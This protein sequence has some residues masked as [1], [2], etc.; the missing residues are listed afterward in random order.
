MTENETRDP[1]KEAQEIE[2]FRR[3]IRDWFAKRSHCELPV[4]LKDLIEVRQAVLQEVC[5][6]LS[7][8]VSEYAARI[9]LTSFADRQFFSRWLNDVSRTFGVSLVCP[10]TG[11]T[12]TLSADRGKAYPCGRFQVRISLENGTRRPSQSSARVPTI[13]FR[14]ANVPELLKSDWERRLRTANAQIPGPSGLSR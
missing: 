1:D 13:M 6:G 8:R 4:I 11:R 12:A 9:P 2:Q 5:D 14:P 3:L 7:P 10:R